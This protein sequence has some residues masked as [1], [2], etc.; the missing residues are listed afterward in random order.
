MK[1]SET[2]NCYIYISLLVRSQLASLFI[3]SL[4]IIRS[5]HYEG[6]I[7]ISIVFERLDYLSDRIIQFG[8]TCIVIKLLIRIGLIPI[9]WRSASFSS[10]AC[11]FRRIRANKGLMTI[12]ERNLCCKRSWGPT[13]KHLCRLT[14]FCKE[15]IESICQVGGI[16]VRRGPCEV[17]HTMRCTGIIPPVVHAALW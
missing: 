9:Q 15:S 10:F 12:M 6:I 8:K 7:V 1:R 2:C 11:F 13:S 14:S 5:Q 16:I 17:R 3:T 4:T